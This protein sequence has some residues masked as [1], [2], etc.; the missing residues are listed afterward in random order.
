MY[1]LHPKD[2]YLAKRFWILL[3]IENASALFFY[4]SKTRSTRVIL[5][6]KY[7]Q[8]WSFAQYIGRV[9][10]NEAKDYDFFE[11]IDVIV[12]VPLT[13]GREKERGYNQS[14][15]FA[16]GI[17]EI[18]GIPI[19]KDAV[20]RISFNGS[21]T[22]KSL[23]ERRENVKGVFKLISSANIKGKHVLI[24]D[25][26]ITTGATILSCAEELMKGDV[27]SLS[28]ASIGYVKH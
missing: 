16:L 4:N 8:K 12:P 26:V 3:P 22:R 6:I 7:M 20:S 19:V 17:K 2:N 14:Y 28:I 1:H 27:K 15:H 24:V 13:K 23:L 11:G 10:A 9:F 5:Q 21:Q 25:D 18:T